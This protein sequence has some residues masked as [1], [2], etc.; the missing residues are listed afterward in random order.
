MLRK[1]PRGAP[2]V[3]LQ[4]HLGGGSAGALACQRWRAG[5]GFLPSSE[6]AARALQDSVPAGAPGPGFPEQ[7]R[8]NSET[9]QYFPI[10]CAA[11]LP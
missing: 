9:R 4:R 6:T 5:S 11:R 1:S 10:I 8:A 3:R 7:R 2:A